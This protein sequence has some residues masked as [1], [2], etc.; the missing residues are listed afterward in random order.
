MAES[1]RFELVTIDDR[2]QREIMRLRNSLPKKD[3]SN[4]VNKLTNFCKDLMMEMKLEE[5]ESQD[6]YD[7]KLFQVQVFVKEGGMTYEL[8]SSELKKSKNR[9]KEEAAINALG[10]LA[11]NDAEIQQLFARAATRILSHSQNQI[12]N[13]H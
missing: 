1:D 11:A 6:D 4:P 7:G 13:D 9:A 5:T 10:R 12:N 2:I 8:A 3:A